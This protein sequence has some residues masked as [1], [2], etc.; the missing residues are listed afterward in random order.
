MA[1]MAIPGG[2]LADAIAITVG[3]AA[4]GGAINAGSGLAE[5]YSRLDKATNEELAE[6]SPKFKAMLEA[7]P[8]HPDVVRQQFMRD[9]AGW[10][11][12]LN[13]LIGAA[14]NAA[15]PAG[16]LARRVGSG[17]GSTVLG[18]GGRGRLGSAG[19]GAIEG[20]GTEAIESGTSDVI[21]QQ[22]LVDAELQKHIDYAQ[23]GRATLEGAVLGG[24]AGGGFGSLHSTKQ[25][26]K[27]IE[28]VEAGVADTVVT[29]P[30]LPGVSGPS[31]VPG[32][33]AT[34]MPAPTVPAKL[35]STVEVAAGG[36][37]V[38]EGTTGV[39]GKPVA[40]PELIGDPQNGPTRSRRD[41]GATARV[42]GAAN[43]TMA[44]AAG[45]DADITA[46]F[47]ATQSA[48]PSAG[49]PVAGMAAAQQSAAPAPA[50]IPQQ[51][52]PPPA[53]GP[54]AAGVAA[55]EQSV[56]PA[57]VRS[58]PVAPLDTGVNV[59]ERPESLSAQIAQIGSGNRRAVMFP[60]GPRSRLTHWA[61]ERFAQDHQPARD[62]H[63]RSQ[64]YKH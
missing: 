27:A 20:A 37:Q 62:V 10:G 22:S 36:A 32:V 56:A 59:P 16:M 46:A 34:A 38:K 47:S 14:T 12:A 55:A 42:P 7:D 35:P 9:A 64:A 54:P 26:A 50:P 51:V 28:D 60:R 21:N 44:N 33:A 8:E 48:K 24:I 1:A 5:F 45:V 15:G 31:A 43:V 61:G 3:V 29:A 53:A 52:T 6:Q 18:A 17:A 49:P 63:L 13:G 40:D 57:P 11:P 2:L 4:A 41:Y 58:P 23:T 19:I 39:A 25:R 30:P